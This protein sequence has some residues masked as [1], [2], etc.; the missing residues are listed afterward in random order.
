[1]ALLFYSRLVANYCKFR[2]EKDLFIRPLTVGVPS[3]CKP[4]SEVEV[5]D[6]NNKKHDP[7]IDSTTVV[8]A[9]T[10]I[11]YLRSEAYKE[12]YGNEPVWIQYRRN[13]KGA[14][15]PLK[16]RK[17]CIRG[18]IISTGNPCPICR[19]EYLVLHHENV[20]LLNQFISPHTGE[21]FSYSKTGLCQRRHLELLVAIEKA[22]DYGFITFDVPFRE[23][24]Y[25]LY[26][27]L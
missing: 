26:Y 8:P 5:K 1:M 11:R 18:G 12:T 9:E 20:D 4:E 3:F 19:D 10:S 13:H 23:Y 7:S 25:S 24:D 17:T 27:K 21:V 22:K 6:D 2:P 14:F 15:P 16:T